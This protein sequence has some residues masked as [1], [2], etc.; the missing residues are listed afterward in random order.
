MKRKRSVYAKKGAVPIHASERRLRPDD[1]SGRR[2]ADASEA[3]A[4]YPTLPVHSAAIFAFAV[5]CWLRLANF[6]LA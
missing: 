3:R 6:A 4:Y 2:A 1:A 5:F